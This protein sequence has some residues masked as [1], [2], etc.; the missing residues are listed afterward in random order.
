MVNEEFTK[1]T[2]ILTVQL[3]PSQP[4]AAWLRCM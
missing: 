1:Q 2:Q 4:T 3:E